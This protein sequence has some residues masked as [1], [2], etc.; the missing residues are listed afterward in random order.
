LITRSAHGVLESS[1][2]EHRRAFPALALWL[3]LAALFGSSAQTPAQ[4]P[5]PEPAAPGAA[6]EP[7]VIEAVTVEPADPA[8]DTLCRLKVKLRNAGTQTASQLGFT[9]KVNGQELATYR[10]QLFMFPVDAGATIE[11]KLYNFWST[12]TS[13]PAPADGKLT[14]EVILN[15]ARWM[16]IGMEGEVEVW[17]PGEA[18][19]GLPVTQSVTLAMKR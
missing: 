5:A 14:I 12:E 10:N 9:V 13:R 18:V 1:L 3:A 2:G 19:P 17:T 6:T 16:T 11:L 15:E 7:L 4:E 8:A